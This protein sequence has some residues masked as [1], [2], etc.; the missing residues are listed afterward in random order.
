MISGLAATQAAVSSTELAV[1][2]VQYRAVP[3]EY[4]LDGVVEAIN[5]TTVSAQTRGQVDEILFDV[6]DFVERGEVIVRLRDNEQRARQAQAAADVNSAAAKREQA[7]DEYERIRGLFDTNA[8]SASAMDKADAER[9]SAAAAY[10]AAR[11]RLEEANE[12]LT[13][14]EILAPYSGI[15][16]ERHVELGEIANPGEPVM[17]G[18]SLDELRVI[19]DVPQS[20]IPTIR[21]GGKALV[22]L[23][24]GNPVE[25]GDITVFPYA[26]PESN[27]FSVR[28]NLPE[29]NSSLFPGMFVDTRFVTGEKRELTVPRSAL[30]YRSEVT[31]V[32]VVDTKKRVHF[33]Q[34]RV[35]RD[36]GDAVVVLAGLSEGEQVAKDP[37]A[38][39]A[40]LK[41]QRKSVN[42]GATHD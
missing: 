41:A 14:T 21:A 37:I 32:Y 39:A 28:V 23:P 11:A 29:G 17:S 16:T 33:R 35:G 3:R 10:E 4:R 38:A 6:D 13:Y 34:I 40:V 2:V 8:I 27:T 30:V 5:R 9:K 22:Y 31:G 24:D 12:Q 19:V 36:L 42:A 26:D 1:A 18:L 20:V 15:V 25:T 7:R